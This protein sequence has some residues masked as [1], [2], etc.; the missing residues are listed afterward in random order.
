MVTSTV[1]HSRFNGTAISKIDFHATVEI[2]SRNDKNLTIYERIEIF[3][4]LSILS[5]VDRRLMSWKMVSDLFSAQNR[6][7]HQDATAPPTKN[8]HC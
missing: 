2:S 8:V 1:L 6:F 7:H 3:G 5:A 4:K